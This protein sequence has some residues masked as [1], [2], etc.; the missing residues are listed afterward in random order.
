M[1]FLSPERALDYVFNFTQGTDGIQLESGA[2][3]EAFLATG[4]ETVIS[5]MAG[6]RFDTVSGDMLFIEDITL[7]ELSTGDFL[8]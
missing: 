2:D 5:N 3:I 8:A 6:V 7:A 1:D 4:Y